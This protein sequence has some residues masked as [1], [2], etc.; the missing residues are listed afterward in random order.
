MTDIAAD[1]RV[2][3]PLPGAGRG[4]GG[5]RLGPDPQPGD[6]GRQHLQRLAGR[7]HRARRCSSTAPTVVA[8][9]PGGTPPDP[10]RRLLRPVRRDDA[11]AGASWSPRSSCR[12]PARRMGAVHLRRTRR[13]GHDLASVTLCCGVDEAGRD[14]ARLRQR[15][16]AAGPRRRR[17][18][19]PR[20]PGRAGRRRRPR[21]SSG[22]SPTPARRRARC[23]RAPSTAWRCCASS[24]ARALRIAIERLA[25]GE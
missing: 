3:A 9:G 5:R 24:A 22:C 11:R 19:R 16:A 20:R 25:A 18:R 21:S 6:P 12:C 4:G 2:R 14:P 23:G 17:E 1:P 13:R 10:D 7:R 15:R 8:A